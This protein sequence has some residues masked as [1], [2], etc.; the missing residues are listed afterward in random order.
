[1]TV[2]IYFVHD[3]CITVC[4]HSN[5]AVQ[6]LLNIYLGAIQLRCLPHVDVECM[7]AYQLLLEVLV[8]FRMK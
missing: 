6:V 8:Y 5:H 3:S 7:L 2:C 1:M 4:A